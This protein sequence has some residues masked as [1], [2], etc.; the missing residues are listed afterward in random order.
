MGLATWRWDRRSRWLV[1]QGHSA[2]TDGDGFA[3][4][5]GGGLP[6]QSTWAGTI[7]PGRGLPSAGDHP[8]VPRTRPFVAAACRATSI[9][10]MNFHRTL[11]GPP[12]GR[13][14]GLRGEVHHRGHAGLDS[15]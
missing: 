2:V 3:E 5:R 4:P 7:R 15:R 11:P 10:R 14:H 6:I 1:E 13:H 12:R 9:Q 8:A